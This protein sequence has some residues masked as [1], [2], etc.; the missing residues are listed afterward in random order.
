MKQYW[1]TLI[2][3]C[4]DSKVVK[5]MKKNPD[6]LAILIFLFGLGTLLTATVQAMN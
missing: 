5:V 3:K 2:I 1:Q 4:S 6:T